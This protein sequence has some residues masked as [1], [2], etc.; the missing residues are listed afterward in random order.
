MRRFRSISLVAVLALGLSLT[1]CA[2][3]GSQPLAQ[4]GAATNAISVS[5]S[6][7]SAPKVSMSTPLVAE[8]TECNEVIAGSGEKIQDGQMVTVDLSVYNGTTGKLISETAF[9]GSD[10]Q[11][12]VMNANLLPGLRKG[13]SCASEGSRVVIVVPPSDAFGQAGN[14][15]WNVS[16]TDTLVFVIDVDRVYLAKANGTPQLSQDGMPMVVLAPNGQPGITVPKAAA[17]T[18]ERIS[19]LKKGNGPVV[20]SGSKVTVHYTG[21]IWADGSVFDS[22]WTTGKP[23]QFVVG[24]GKKDKGEVIQGF[25]DAVIGQTVGSQILVVIPPELA[26][27]NQS[28]GKIPANSTLVFVIDI[29]GVD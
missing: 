4:T 6:F 20:E 22:S 25:S 10:S 3:G 9:D 13:L 21:V 2:S 5:G 14:N 7:G 23:A 27:G 24:D 15:K 28:A 12:I 29:L 11:S 18:T 26:Y 17:P 16:A 1:A 8:T 19:V